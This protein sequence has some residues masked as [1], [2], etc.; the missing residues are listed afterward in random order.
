[1]S[2]V[3]VIKDLAAENAKL[4]GDNNAMTA[5]IDIASVVLTVA[6]TKLR[7]Y[8][9]R[10]GCLCGKKECKNPSVYVKYPEANLQLAYME[11][12]DKKCDFKFL[13]REKLASS[14]EEEALV[15]SITMDQ[16][17]VQEEAI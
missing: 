13:K 9:D 17:N 6:Q 14:A 4:Q 8:E 1:M 3:D 2:V 7:Q 11:A 10:F 16:I 12:I 5:T 15:G